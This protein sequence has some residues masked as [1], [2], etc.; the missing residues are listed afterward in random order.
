MPLNLLKKYNEL[1]DLEYLPDDKRTISLRNIFI[2][3]IENNPNFSFRGKFIFPTPRENGDVA[4]QNLFNHLT[5]KKE[6][7]NKD[8]HRI[9][10]I[11]R[12]KRLHWIKYHIEECK[13]EEMLVFSVDEPE[14]IRTYI[15]DI[16][17]MYVIVLEPNKSKTNYYL[18]TAYHLEGKDAKRNKII[19]K[20]KKRRLSVVY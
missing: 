16:A 20:Y 12:S 14:G 9:F 13:K 17:E 2:R 19:A 6:L 1:L 5:R 8:N 10:D 7:E 11:S 15:Y 3:D 4:M 18:L